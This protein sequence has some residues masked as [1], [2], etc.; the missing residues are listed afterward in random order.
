MILEEIKKG[1]KYHHV[2]VTRFDIFFKKK[3]LPENLNFSEMNIYSI[4]ENSEVIC[5]NFYLFPQSY[6]VKFTQ[7]LK[8]VF[9]IFR[10][11]KEYIVPNYL[12]YIKEYIEED[13]PINFIKNE[14][15]S[16][17]KLDSYILN[18]KSPFENILFIISGNG[19]NFTRY[20][21]SLH[22][23]IITNMTTRPEILIYLKNQKK[24][25]QSENDSRQEILEYMKSHDYYK[26]WDIMID[27]QKKY[28]E[29]N[30]AK[31][32]YYWY[33]GNSY[34]EILKIEEEIERQY[35]YYMFLSPNL[36]F[37]QKIDTYKLS[38][39]DPTL[40][41][42]SRIYDGENKYQ[43]HM[44]LIPRKYL[45]K[46]FNNTWEIFSKLNDFEDQKL[47]DIF[48]S[49]IKDTNYQIYQGIDYSIKSE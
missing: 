30:L 33:L 46:Y 41:Y 4:L 49:Q 27:S 29:L 2:L 45:K 39:E 16:V 34:Q 35:D 44:I 6:L 1:E 14:Y 25:S 47:E 9:D 10:N 13:I 21:E 18:I 3:L 5:D 7:L 22:T 20:Y 8:N 24:I 38:L 23:N 26:I 42:N 11:K 28:D 36:Y 32:K 15:V 19:S 43:E 37:N 48:I 40:F 17:G 31:F 12:H